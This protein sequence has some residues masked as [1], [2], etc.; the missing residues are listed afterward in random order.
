MNEVK[1]GKWVEVSSVLRHFGEFPE[2]RKARG[3]RHKLIDIIC[4]SVLAVICRANTFAEIEQYGKAKEEWLKQFLELPFGIPSVDTFERVFALM[5]PKAWAQWFYG[6]LG[7]LVLPELAEGEEEV[8]AI[9]GK[10]SRRS[11]GNGLGAL[12]TVSVWSS[13]YEVV[14]AQE[15]VDEKSNE[16]KVI[17]DLLMSI[18]AAGAIVTTD[19]MGTQKNIAWL[20]RDQYAH[21]VLALKDNHPKLFADTLWLFTHAD[22]LHWEN[23]PHSYAQTHNQGH[24]RSEKRE[25]W[26]LG[27][28]DILDDRTAWRDLNALV[29]IRSTRT[30]GDKTSVEDRFFITSLPL[31]A[32]KIMRVIRLHWGIENGLHW[33]LD[34][35][36]REDLNRARNKN[37]QANL[38]AVRHLAINVLKQ[39][40]SIKAG[41]ETK[42]ARASWDNNF[43]LSLLAI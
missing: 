9:D 24:G 43:L 17:P 16:I 33:V 30:I 21:Y 38:V 22:S 12:H 39:D 19:A 10:T 1:E 14:I 37:A 2:P 25:C 35:A 5:N 36:F 3:I 13:Q 41:I 31:D 15:Q 20:I 34:T 26:V 8:L 6:W 7:E 40:K 42:R 28:L 11:H 32:Q 4:I 27:N 18:N 29:R 23:V